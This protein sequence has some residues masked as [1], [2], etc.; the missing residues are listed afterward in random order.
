MTTTAKKL[1]QEFAD[2]KSY[3]SYRQLKQYL[4]SNKFVYADVSIK[5]ALKLLVDEKLIFSAGR[6]YYSNINSEVPLDFSPIDSI[7]QIVKQKFPLLQFSVWST[8]QIN[9]AFHHTQNKFFTFVYADK[10]SLVFL[11]DHLVEAGF[12]TFLNPIRRDL[13]K[14]SFS[15]IDSIILRPLIARSVNIGNYASIEKIIV[16]LSLESERLNILEKSEYTRVFEHLLLNYRLNLS[17]LLDYGE[18]RKIMTKIKQLLIKYTNPTL[19]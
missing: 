16:D 7:V 8:K 13:V 15:D 17:A 5:K 12:S 14:T 11:R 9:F 1:I 19:V 6:G 10:D 18:R 4:R 3:F 2:H